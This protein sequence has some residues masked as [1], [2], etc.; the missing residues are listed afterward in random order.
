MFDKI[1]K[2][3]AGLFLVPLFLSALFYTIWPDLV[4]IGGLT[5]AT[6]SGDSM[7]F[8]LGVLCFFSGTTID[9]KR[10]VRVLK[11]QGVLLV[12]KFILSLAFGLFAIKLLGQEGFFGISTMA[13]VVGISSLN[14][15]I[16]LSLIKEYGTADDT[17]AFGL[18]GV[19]SLPIIPVIVYSITSAAGAEMD[20]MPIVSTL[21]PIGLG[22]LIGNLDVKFAQ[23]F[24][25]GSGVLLPILGWNIGQGIDLVEVAKSGLHGLLLVIIYYIAM[26]P[27]FFIDKKVLKQDGIGAVSMLSIAGISVSTLGILATAHPELQQYVSSATGQLLTATVL[28]SVTTSFIVKK[29]HR[30]AYAK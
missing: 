26:S 15:A 25:P 11:R 4:R 19:F 8:I 14:P 12:V 21:V 13:L 2:V 1:T 7:N 24:A 16:Y 3:P 27:I 5:E 23:L 9:L 6:F 20:W 28:T 17:A 30:V 18:I 10:L 29:L 22:M